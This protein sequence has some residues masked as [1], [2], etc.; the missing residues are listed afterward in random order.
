MKKLALSTVSA[1]ALLSSGVTCE[2]ADLAVRAAPAPAPA[3]PPSYN[4]TGFYVGVNGGG[5]W[6]SQ[7]PFNIISNRFDQFRTGISGGEFGG[8]VGGQ[9]QAGHVL[10][11]LEADLD[12]AR[13]TGSTT[14][15]P[16][17]AGIVPAGVGPVTAQ[18]RIDWESTI[19]VRAGYANN[20]WLF[21]STGGLAVLGAK[22]NL[23]TAAGSPFVCGG[24]IFSTCTGANKQVGGVLGGGVEYAFTPD[25]SAKVEYLYITAVSLDVSRHS[26]VRAGLNYHFSGL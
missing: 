8:T 14:A 3:A 15:T 7:D 2:A 22:T 16:T 12:W 19:R 26:E 24:A 21:Y 9:A 25:L 10:L 18:T 17:I 23:T 6:G 13:I 20:N 1:V 11:G 4:W 5:A